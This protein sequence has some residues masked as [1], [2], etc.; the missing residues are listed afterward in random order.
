MS[1][2]RGARLAPPSSGRARGDPASRRTE[3]G[4]R[5]MAPRPPQSLSHAPADINVAWCST[6][7]SRIGAGFGQNLDWAPGPM[8]TLCRLPALARAPAFGGLDLRGLLLDYSAPTALEVADGNWLAAVSGFGAVPLDASV[9]DLAQA[10]DTHLWPACAAQRTRHKNW[11]HWC[12]VLTWGIVRKALPL[13]LP[14]SRDTLKAIT[15]DLVS[16]RASR[17]QIVAV[18]SAI[19]SRHRYFGLTPP[20]HEKGE[21]SRWVRAISCVMGRPLALKLPVHKSI[22][23]TLLAW[24]PTGV[25]D[26]RCRLLTALA[27][28]ACLRVSEVAALQ[29]CDLWF[30][31]FTGMGI[32]GYEGSCGVHI[33]KQKNDQQRKGHMPGIGVSRDPTLDLVAQ[34]RF[35]MEWMGLAT[36]PG[37]TKRARPAARCPACPPLFSKTGKGP[38]GLTVATYVPCSRQLVSQCIK[39][40]VAAA[41]ADPSRFSG[42]S[43]RKGGISTAVEAGVEENILF[44][45]SGHGPARAARAYQHLRD[46]R[47]LLETFAAF[48]L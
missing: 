40:A 33:L 20:I 38:G 12:T 10:F 29:V 3:P 30:D 5:R 17:S 37:C 9:H 45:Q 44:L 42:I 22:I 2:P 14:M 6:A 8:P 46:P 24:R 26:N 11:R 43:A 18:W 34:L 47:R 19:S 36:Q 15:W 21:F 23:R 1:A 28:I 31:H 48:D 32:P 25:A 4:R 41:G 35:W 27:T 39:D 16:F 7:C 13:L